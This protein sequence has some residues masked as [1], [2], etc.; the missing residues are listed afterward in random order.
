MLHALRRPAFVLVNTTTFTVIGTAVRQRILRLS[1][2]ITATHHLKG[3]WIAGQSAHVLS[4]S[5]TARVLTP[6]NQY[7]FS[8]SCPGRAFVSQG[9]RS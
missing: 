7:L 5:Q 1:A 8:G 2:R 9:R 3:K 4:S 6:E